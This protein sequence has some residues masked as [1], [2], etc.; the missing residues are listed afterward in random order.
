MMDRRGERIAFDLAVRAGGWHVL[1][2]FGLGCLPAQFVW[3]RARRR[4]RGHVVLLAAGLCLC[5]CVAELLV[6]AHL[7]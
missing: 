5:W 4:R 3:S 1:F 6:G 2:L 7:F